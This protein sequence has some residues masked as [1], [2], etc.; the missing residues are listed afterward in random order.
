MYIAEMIW[1]YRYMKHD[2]LLREYTYHL[3]LLSQ[4][5]WHYDESIID[6]PLML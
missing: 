2:V 5:L 1:H 3:L 6:F 4:Q